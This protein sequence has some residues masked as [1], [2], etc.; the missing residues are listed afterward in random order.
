MTRL[1]SLFWLG[2]AAVLIG[3]TVSGADVSY[4]GMIKSQQFVQTNAAVPILPATN[5]FVFSAFVVPTTNKLVT[6]ASVKPP[7]STATPSRTLL[8][9]PGGGSLQFEE[10][11]NSQSA[12]D[13]AYPTGSIF[14]VPTYSFAMFCFHDG[15]RSAGLGFGLGFAPG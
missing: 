11:F 5:A 7:V 8:V 10:R 14:N 3:D 6:N 15:A 12:L 9:Q 13:M 1:F 2:L 4:Y